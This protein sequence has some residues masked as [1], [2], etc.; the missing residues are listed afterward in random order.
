[1][2]RYSVTCEIISGYEFG[3]PSILGLYLKFSLAFLYKSIF[4]VWVKIKNV[5]ALNEAQ[6]KSYNAIQCFHSRTTFMKMIRCK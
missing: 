1:M 3:N 4:L 5:P 6:V 2:K